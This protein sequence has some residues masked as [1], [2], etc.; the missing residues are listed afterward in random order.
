MP[1]AMNRRASWAGRAAIGAAICLALFGAPAAMAQFGTIFGEPPPRPPGNVPSRPPAPEQGRQ[2]PQRLPPGPP[3]SQQSRSNASKSPQQQGGASARWRAVAAFAAAAR[4]ARRSKPARSN[5]AR[6][7]N[8]SSPGRR[9]VCRGLPP[10]QRPAARRA[11]AGQHRAAA[12]RR[13]DQRAAVAE[14]P[15]RAGG[16][17][18][19]RQDHRPH[20]HR[21]TSRSTRP[22]NSARCR[23]CRASCYTRPP[24]EAANTDAFLEVSEVTLQGEVRRIFTGWMFASSPGLHAVEHPI[25]DIWLTDCKQPLI[26]VAEEPPPAKAGADAAGAPAAPAAAA[27]RPAAAAT[28][29][30]TVEHAAATRFPAADPLKVYAQVLSRYPVRKIH[31]TIARH[32]ARNASVQARL[33]STPTSATPKKLQRKPLIR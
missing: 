27:A 2:F 30:I 19:A 12:R 29:H 1:V 24:T 31:H 5:P 32:S 7:R 3:P 8:C 4:R 26:K 16:V 28:S 22:C 17:F 23:S 6:R 13:G 33:I 21:S 9:R 15:E 11:A 10:G 20:H 18:R 14:N 25:Y